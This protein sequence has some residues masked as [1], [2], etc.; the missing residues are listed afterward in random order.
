[1]KISL[2]S[3]AR[4]L[5]NDLEYYKDFLEVLDAS[6]E[7]PLGEKCDV[8]I[9]VAIQDV[10]GTDVRVSILSYKLAVLLHDFIMDEVTA[11]EQKI[12]EL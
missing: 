12:H 7:T 5:F 3:E 4:Q 10:S 2:I 8:R 1:M 11:I 9:T 6:M